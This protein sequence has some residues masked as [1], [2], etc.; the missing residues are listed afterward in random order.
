MV[1]FASDNEETVMGHK[2]SAST[3]ALRSP[4]E[5]APCKENNSVLVT[6]ILAQELGSP[7]GKRGD[8]VWMNMPIR[9]LLGMTR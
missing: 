4:G 6:R 5:R 8:I 3:S 2:T 1:C 9:A 7:E